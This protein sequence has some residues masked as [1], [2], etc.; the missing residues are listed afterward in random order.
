MSVV[1]GQKKTNIKYLKEK[2]NLRNVFVVSKEV[3]LKG[4]TADE[5]QSSNSNQYNFMI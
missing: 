1:I 2:Y 3:F 4:L 5:T